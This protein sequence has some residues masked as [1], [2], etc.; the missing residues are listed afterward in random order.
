LKSIKKDYIKFIPFSAFIVIPG[1]ELLLPPFLLV[2]P[3]SVPS[4]FLSKEEKDAK[5][6]T[7]LTRQQQSAEKLLYIFSNYFAKLVRDP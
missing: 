4:Q 3:N 2:F 5:I 1:A 6:R 7:I